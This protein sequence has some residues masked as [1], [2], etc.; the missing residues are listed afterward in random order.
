MEIIELLERPNL[1]AD[2]KMANAHQNLNQ[3]LS[4]LRNRELPE[5][6][7]ISINQKVEQVNSFTGS[8]KELRKQYNKAK[9]SILTLIEQKV[10]IVTK[11]HY[12]TRW[13]AIGMTAFG[14]PFGVLF[15]TM[16]DNMAYLGIGLPI[17]MAIGLAIGS[18]M[19]QKAQAEGRQLDLEIKS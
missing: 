2:E 8:D 4:E 18:G 19:D 17:G 3:L 11:G 5:E 12:R 7:I 14:L 15:G 9:T 6:L 13:M 16:L 10:K 1:N